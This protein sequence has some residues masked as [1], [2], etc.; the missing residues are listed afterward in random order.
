LIQTLVISLSRLFLSNSVF[1]VTVHDPICTETGDLEA[2]L[3]G[4]FLPIPSQ[5]VF[6][7]T[8]ASEY[9]RDKAPGAIIAKKERIL[10]NAERERIKLTV[11][12][13]GDRPIQV[14]KVILSLYMISPMRYFYKIGSHY[15]FIETNS[16][17]TFDRAKAYG[18]RLDI[19]AGTAVRFE[20][21]DS[22][23]VTLCSIAGAKIISGGNNLASGIVDL[24]KTD[25]ILRSLVQKGFGHTPEPGA[26]EVTSN[27]DIGRDVYISMYGPT[28]GDRVRLGDTALWVEVERDEVSLTFQWQK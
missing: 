12:N 2:A 25:E 19:P 1:L 28:V 6:P 15:H 13:N 7:V 5:D 16:A 20:P 17:L 26:M 4:S 8:E 27:T 11:T 22:K 3:Y 10:I 9:A 21:G 14:S 18:K 23:T 24:R